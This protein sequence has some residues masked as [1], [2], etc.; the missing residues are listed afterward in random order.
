MSVIKRDRSASAKDL[1]DALEKFAILLSDQ[2]END[3][4]KLLRDSANQIKSAAAGSPQLK[5]AINQVF[6]AFDGD[7]ELNAYI[8]EKPNTA[9]WTE[10]D[11]LSQ[12]ATRVLNLTRRL[13]S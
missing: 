5:K 9:E 7:H 1:T 13:R 2:S 10:A 3:A 12:A 4:A 6:E 8:I 11:E